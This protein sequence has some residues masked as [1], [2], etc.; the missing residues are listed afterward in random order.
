MAQGIEE[1]HTEVI[2]MNWDQI[3]G[4]WTQ[5]KGKAREQWGK[6]TDS[7]LERIAGKKDQLVGAIQE[8]YGIAREAAEKQVEEFRQRH[9]PKTASKAR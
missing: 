8:K 9:F 5:Y 3:E 2:P 6:L 7:D 4:K 1:R